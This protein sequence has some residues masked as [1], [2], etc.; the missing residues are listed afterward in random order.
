[1]SYLNSFGPVRHAIVAAMVL[2]LTI[3]TVCRTEFSAQA[4]PGP[5][6]SHA[7]VPDSNTDGAAHSLKEADGS[8]KYT[9]RLV[10]ETSPYLLLHAHNPVDWYPWGTEAIQRARREDKPIFLSVGYATCYWCHVMERLVFS[11]STIAEQMNGHFVNIKV[12]REERPDVDEIYMT[13]TRIITGHGGW[14]NSVFLTPELNPFFAGTYFPP[15]D[16]PRYN[17]PGFPRV[18]QVIR[19]AWADRRPDVIAQ[20]RYIS[21]AMEKIHL[22][23]RPQTADISLNH[24][25]LERSIDRLVQSYD[26]VHGGFGD[27]P[28]FPPDQALDL[29]MSQHQH[30]NNRELLDIVT[31][32][33]DNMAAGGIFDHLGGGFH[34]YATDRGW[35]VPHFEKMLYNQ[36]QLT[37]IYLRAYQISRNP[38]YRHTAEDILR[39]VTR[40]MTSPE[41]AFYSAL[42]SETSGKEGHYY[43]WNPTAIRSILKEDAD[44]FLKVYSLARMPEG[45]GMVLY[46]PTTLGAAADALSLPYDDLRDRLRPLKQKLLSAREQRDRPL[47]DDKIITAWN[48]LMIA[49]FA[50]AYATLNSPPYLRAARRAANFVLGRM[51]DR[52]GNLLRIYRNGEVKETAFQEDYAFLIQ[53]LVSLYQASGE[54]R[55]LRDAEA[56]SERMRSLYWDDDGGG[57]FFTSGVEHLITRIKKP[58]DGAIPSGNSVAVHALLSLHNLTKKREYMDL[59]SRSLQAFSSLMQTSQ[60][61]FNNMYHGLLRYLETNTPAPTPNAPGTEA[62]GVPETNVP[63]L[64]ASHEAVNARAFVLSHPPAA[65]GRLE[66]VV[67]LTIKKGWHINANPATLDFLVPTTL[68][69]SSEHPFDV[70]EIS[71][72]SAKRIRFAFADQPLDVYEGEVTIPATL[73]IGGYRSGVVRLHLVLEFQACDATRCLPPSSITLP[74]E[75]IPSE[76]RG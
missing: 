37:R 17:R 26:P 59:A 73:K 40:E 13:A 58:Y 27:A 63:I 53:G 41:G 46:M 16:D 38:D 1:M 5:G 7:A 68:S 44:L 55:Y 49:A 10:H 65:G 9:N 60:S 19:N 8:W 20:S 28:K 47:L 4:S 34:R 36:A 29:L 45:D 54:S 14:P 70:M 76:P 43:L 50:D 12:D 56:L 52:D 32:T 51:R 75:V 71:Y 2:P 3:G 23:P 11:D 69:I 24:S 21:S 57:F 33:L 22:V 62:P 74:I 39:Y 18:L 64:A 48:G 72:P 30:R 66:L 15:K 31:G 35:F 42:D 6:S 67:T 61:G 25:T